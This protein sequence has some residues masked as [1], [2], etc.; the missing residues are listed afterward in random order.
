L[1]T[2]CFTF[3]F[4]RDR[5]WTIYESPKMAKNHRVWLES[6]RDAWD[7][8]WL[9]GFEKSSS[10]SPDKNMLQKNKFPNKKQI[11]IDKTYLG[12]KIGP[13]SPVP[14]SLHPQSFAASWAKEGVHLKL[15]GC[16]CK[17]RVQVP[18]LG[19]CEEFGTQ[20][21]HGFPNYQLQMFDDFSGSILEHIQV[22]RLDWHCFPILAQSSDFVWVW[23]TLVSIIMC[24]GSILVIIVWHLVRC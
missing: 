5:W 17:W 7:A 20:M 21:N 10:D 3:N 2:A 15:S 14:E 11:N 19:I 1:L 4:W 12:I 9:V 22:C 6:I 18:L 13:K 23:C 16:H 24:N 8:Y